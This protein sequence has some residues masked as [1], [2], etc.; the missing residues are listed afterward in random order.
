MD[1]NQD[2]I[3]LVALVL[4]KLTQDETS[5]NI[6]DMMGLILDDAASTE[7][8]RRINIA[9]EDF[10]TNCDIDVIHDDISNITI[11]ITNI[12]WFDRF[13]LEEYLLINI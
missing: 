3:E 9:L 13:K 10:N 2:D 5:Y 6:S 8:C 4:S 12:N 11:Q 7:I 1:I